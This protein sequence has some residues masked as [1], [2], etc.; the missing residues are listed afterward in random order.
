MLKKTPASLFLIVSAVTLCIYSDFVLSFG[1]REV[2]KVERGLSDFWFL[3]P[4][5]LSSSPVMGERERERERGPDVLAGFDGEM[6]KG[7][8]YSRG[9]AV[10]L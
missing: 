8:A 4:S 5:F 1:N 9:L 6:K 10:S 7:L 2:E 3:T